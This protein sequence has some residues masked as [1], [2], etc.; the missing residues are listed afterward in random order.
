MKK[1]EVVRGQLNKALE[2][3]CKKDVVL[4]ISRQLDDLIVEAMKIQ[5]KKYINKGADP[6]ITDPPFFM[7][8]V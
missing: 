4:T 6:G 7:G 8:T 3:G 2:T 5:N 1:I